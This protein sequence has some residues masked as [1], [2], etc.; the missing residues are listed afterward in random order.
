MKRQLVFG[1]ILSA[2][3]AV[4]VAAQQT[5]GGAQSGQG[6]GGQTAG[7]SRQQD[8]RGGQTITVTGC[9]ESADKMAGA[10]GSQTGAQAG[11]SGQR[12]QAGQQASGFILT[13]VS[14]SSTAGGSTAGSRTGTS[15]TAT[16]STAGAGTSSPTT[17]T[18]TTAGTGTSAA[19]RAA[20]TSYRLSGTESQNLQQYVGQ[21][22]EITGTVAG[23]MGGS[24][25]SGT[26]AT[27]EGSRT[28][29]GAGTSTDRDTG[30]RTGTGAAGSATASTGAS[31]GQGQAGAMSTLRVTSVKPVS[32]NC[33]Q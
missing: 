1:T 11:Q 32:G 17:G 13:N 31:S 16:G 27:A 21:R 7:S 33:A 30:G 28:G 4:G 18:G 12:T 6:Q 22:V 29:T 10:A 23:E 8:S 26:G 14:A 9:V 3:L 2:T 24:T 20:A 5:Q 15:G 19:G 25:R